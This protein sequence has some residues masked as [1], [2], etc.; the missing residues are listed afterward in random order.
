MRVKVA[1]FKPSLTSLR[2]IGPG[3]RRVGGELLPDL[4]HERLELRSLF[5]VLSKY[6][7]LGR[8]LGHHDLLVVDLAEQNP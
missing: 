7:P 3:K 2:L 4:V 5:E 1:S 8:H 6:L